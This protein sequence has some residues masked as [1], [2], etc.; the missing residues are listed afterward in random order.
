MSI[1]P[2]I[3]A[4]LRPAASV[5]ALRGDI[6][7]SPL[8]VGLERAR[9]FTRI[10]QENEGA[11]WIVKK[12]MALREHLRTVPL[13]LRPHD[14]IA[15]SI[16]ERPGA[17]PLM[18]ELGIAENDIYTGEY[19]HRCG[20]LRGQVP[21][22]IADYWE[23]RN[24]WGRY[25]AWRRT[26]EGV[27]EPRGEG[28][29]YKFI[30][31]Q[32][33]L[34][35]A[36]SELLSVGLEG[37]LERVQARRADEID[38]DALEFLAAA[39]QAL[40]GVMEWTERYAAF[41][42]EKAGRCHDTTRSRELREM[43][44]I[45]AV[46]PRR[47]PSTFREAL[48]AVWFCHQA[49]HIEGHGYSC[50]PDRL[51]QLLFPFYD[52]DR[53]AGRLNEE[54]ALALCANL[55][56]KMRDNTFWGPEHNLTQGLVV[57]GSTPDGEDQTNDLSWLFIRAAA[58]VSLP[59]PLIWL[60]WHPNIDPAFFDFCLEALTRTGCFPLMMS[61]SA[62]PA[63]LMGL[64]VEREDAFNYVPA[65]CNEIAV[66][67]QAYYNPGASVNYLTALR[68]TMDGGYA[69]PDFGAFVG[70]VGRQMREQVR[71]SCA[72]ERGVLDAQMRWGQT[73]LTSCF[74]DGCV[75]R[76]RDM[77]LGTKYKILSCGGAFFPNM[78]DCLAAVREV[79]YERKEATLEGVAAACRADFAGHEGLRRKLLAAP[80]QG[81]DDP[82]L[83]EIV[84]LVE[85][86]RDEPVKEICRD[87]RDGTPFGN[88]HVVRSAAVRSGRKTG[89]TPDGRRAGKPLAPSVA[90]SC[91]CERNGPTALLNSIL[92]L[93]PVRSWQCGYNVNM[94][95][96]RPTLAEPATRRKV[97]DMLR[98][99]F[100]RGGQEMQ[101]NCVGNDVLRAAQEQ[102]EKHR[103]VVVRV[104]GFSE[105]FVNLTRDIQEEIIARTEY[106]EA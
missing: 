8:S 30:S 12:A 39:E 86:L 51:D 28:A 33:H 55:L 25:R 18:V 50:T 69:L 47:P 70:E 59:E 105:F 68:Q 84:R 22:E 82:R 20:Y 1:A 56:L 40:L 80:K 76:A 11:P 60:R 97:A 71:R 91:G 106:G 19:P 72:R 87:R 62:V 99:Y 34:S 17:M 36:Y 35:P 74:F 79:V 54:E 16:S 96:S 63:M 52:T 46:V 45:A 83:Q 38:P 66:P 29:Y 67:G 43:A 104:A 101:I 75:E 41:L 57:G 26:V 49:I 53:A 90:A 92:M 42:D 73:P 14:L 64:G 10:W 3:H 37:I 100:L 93:D 77:T 32:G 81:N 24:L 58:E 4:N 85:R 13:Y 23:H 27:E 31:N 88:S 2:R 21:A 7:A 89:A 9:A 102:P 61:D 44:R 78:V 15:G 65:G 98:A 5:K 95:L 103:D 6:V 48:Q 94:R